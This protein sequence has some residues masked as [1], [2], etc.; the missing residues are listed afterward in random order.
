MAGIDE[1]TVVE[2][3]KG[4]VKKRRTVP[5]Y[6]LIQ[7]HTAR[8]TGITNMYLANIPSIDIMKISGHKKESNFL[9]YVR[10]SKDETA[11]K[12]AAHPYFNE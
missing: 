10:L 9:K 1:L 2:E 8:R 4:G 5:K 3:I 12:L 7:S 6:E 11:N